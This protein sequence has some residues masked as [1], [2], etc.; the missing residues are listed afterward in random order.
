MNKKNKDIVNIKQPKSPSNN[1]NK[2]KNL[3]PP[4]ILN[5]T[6]LLKKIIKNIQKMKI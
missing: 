1:E 2:P 5:T 6:K 4:K 3:M